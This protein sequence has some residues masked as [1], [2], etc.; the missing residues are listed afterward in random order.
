MVYKKMNYL[1]LYDELT[2]TRLLRY[3]SPGVYLRGWSY[4]QANRVHITHLASDHITSQ[5]NGQT[6]YQV[7]LWL[8]NGGLSQAWRYRLLNHLQQY[9]IRIWLRFFR[10]SLR[11]CPAVRCFPENFF[12]G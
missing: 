7:E 3:A 11:V 4:V 6:T 9:I 8:E 5:V 10:H 1:S 12:F 2:E